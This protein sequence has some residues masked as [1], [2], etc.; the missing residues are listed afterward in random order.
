MSFIPKGTRPSAAVELLGRCRAFILLHQV[1][2]SSH[3]PERLLTKDI[4]RLAFPSFYKSDALEIL[5]LL[6]REGIPADGQGGHAESAG[7]AGC[8]SIAGGGSIAGCGSIADCRRALELLW[9]KRNADG[10]W[11]LEREHKNMTVSVGSA[12]KPNAFVTRRA[13]TVFDMLGRQKRGPL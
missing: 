6:A 2:F 13:S 8:G 10:T 1:C 3:H 7:Q 12:G 11:N 5:W 9:N 4:G